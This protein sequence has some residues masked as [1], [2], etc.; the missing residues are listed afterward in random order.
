MDKQKRLAEIDGMVAYLRANPDTHNASAIHESLARERRKLTMP[1]FGYDVDADGTRI[2]SGTKS[3]LVASDVLLAI[4]AELADDEL[5]GSGK[6]YK[7]IV[8][9]IKEL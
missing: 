5:N 4:A 9:T 3:A 8:V 1:T 6:A 7:A 2:D